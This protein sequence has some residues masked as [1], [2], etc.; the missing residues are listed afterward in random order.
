MLGMH[1]NYG[2]NVLT[3]QADLLIAVGM[4]FDDR[5]TGSLDNYAPD[6]KVIHIEIDAAEID[7]IVKTDAALVADAKEA[8]LAL[9]PLVKENA[10]PEWLKRFEECSVLERKKVIDDDITPG[11]G[12]IKM[13]EA[14]HLLSEMTDGQAAIVA[15]VGQHQMMSARYY[16]YEQPHS[17]ITSGGL[18]T[19]GFALPA[20]LGY[21]V[22]QPEREV[23]AIIGDGCFQMTFQELGTVAQEKLPLKAI[24]MNNNY[25]GMVRQ[26]QELFFEKN[27]S[28]VHLQNPDFP[29][30]CDAF[31]IK[32]RRVEKREDLKEALQE[33][34]DSKEAFVLELVV[35]QEDNVFPMIAAG[36]SVD[37]MRLE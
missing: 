25:L 37:Q 24:V 10:H 16:R 9:L 26:W 30:L 1:G 5:V 32:A 12:R 23:I 35:G 7:K 4:R 14:I 13:A 33:M 20:A 31:G 36:A 15:D 11:E 29:K 17:Y 19:M 8:L 21:K 27:Y 22:G 18:G 6:A 3:N 28:Q 2:P 34:L